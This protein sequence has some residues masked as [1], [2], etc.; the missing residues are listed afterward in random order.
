MIAV[1]LSAQIV[2]VVAHVAVLVEQKIGGVLVVLVEQKIGGVLAVLVEQKIG[3]VLAALVEQ[4][5]GGVLVVLV[6]QKIGG[7]V[8]VPFLAVRIADAAALLAQQTLG[9]AAGHGPLLVL[10]LILHPP[11]LELR[12][13]LS[14][15]CCCHY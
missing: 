3:G 12:L 5:I 7:V 1:V 15:S 6:E 13:S 11:V 9:V 4:K 2:F 8:V 14:V 10:P